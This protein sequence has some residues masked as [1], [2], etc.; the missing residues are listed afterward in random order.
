[1]VAVANGIATMTASSSRL[2]KSSV[3]FTTAMLAISVWWLTQMIP[4]VKKLIR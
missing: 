4:I 2:R 3:R 1:M